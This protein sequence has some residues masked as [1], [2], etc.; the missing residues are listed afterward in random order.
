MYNNNNNV[1][2]VVSMSIKRKQ[3]KN[4]KEQFYTD[5]YIAKRL[6]EY[7]DKKVGFDKFK[8]IVEPSAGNGSFFNNIPRDRSRK[9][10]GLD[11]HPKSKN[12]KKQDFLKW[13]YKDYKYNVDPDKV[14]CIG[15]P[16]FG[17]QST[18]G[19]QFVQKCSEFSN[20][21]AFIL[22]ASF[23][24]ESY[25]RSLPRNFKKQWDII[26]DDDIFID[27]D[28]YIIEQP[29]KTIF[30]YYKN[31]NGAQSPR[32]SQKRK[33]YP[34]DLWEFK[35]KTSQYDRSRSDF[36]IIRAS[37]TPGRAI[38]KNDNRFRISGSTYNDFY[39]KLSP[40]ISRYASDIV[41]DINRYQK[42]GKW[43]FNNTTTFKSI[44]KQQITKV[45]NKI[46][47]KYY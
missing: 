7:F 30:V 44:D 23:N 3:K 34:N 10:I 32:A 25:I 36:R 31:K 9:V 37:G 21:I 8:L 18:L 28:G 33:I 16:P 13:D 41:D 11:L 27:P 14:L 19:K 12:I 15:N 20:H 24:S 6:I 39:I 46:T 22:P 40:E 35:R 5:P 42:Q 38:E 1:C 29:L 45:L 43:K 17:R 26:L 47:N 4:L 2:V